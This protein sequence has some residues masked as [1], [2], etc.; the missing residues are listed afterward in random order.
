MGS[1]HGLSNDG[2]SLSSKCVDDEHQITNHHHFLEYKFCKPEELAKCPSASNVP[3][4]NG[5]IS[6]ANIETVKYLDVSNSIE[7][8]QPCTITKKT[9]HSRHDMTQ[10]DFQERIITGKI[11]NNNL[12]VNSSKDERDVSIADAGNKSRRD[13]P[14]ENGSVGY[15]NAHP[16]KIVPAEIMNTIQR[17]Y[18]FHL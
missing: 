1:Q 5:L 16:S 9:K 17:E 18:K 15:L 4:K 8:H 3:D 2:H 7:N 6:N 12:N 10:V 14:Y 11:P 13:I